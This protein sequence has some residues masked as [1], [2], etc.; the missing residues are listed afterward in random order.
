MIDNGHVPGKDRRRE[1]TLV[2][3]DE[4]GRKRPQDMTDRELAEE[5]V[6]TL[7]AVGDAFETMGAELQ[8]HGPL[9]VMKAFL[10]GSK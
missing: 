1:V 3:R 4:K 7:R 10:T 6:G 2:P 8:K 9:G 5:T